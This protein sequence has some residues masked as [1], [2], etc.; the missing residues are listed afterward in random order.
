MKIRNKR[1]S[2]ADL[3][4]IGRR[5]GVIQL[6]P[7]RHVM[8]PHLIH[9]DTNE[10]ASNPLSSPTGPGGAPG[11]H[12]VAGSQIAVPQVSTSISARSGMIRISWRDSAKLS[13][14]TDI[15]TRCKVSA[16]EPVRSRIKDRSTG[17]R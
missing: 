8:R 9:E 1:Y 17:Q 16:M 13:S 11:F 4:R 15:L 14:K 7:P 10:L 6:V 5:P 2:K 12:N 3:T